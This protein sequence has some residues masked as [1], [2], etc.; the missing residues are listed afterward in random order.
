MATL[1]FLFFVYSIFR[2]LIGYFF[3]LSKYV[4]TSIF[5]LNPS[6]QRAEGS[7]HRCIVGPRTFTLIAIHEKS[8]LAEA[9]EYLHRRVVTHCLFTSVGAS[10]FDMGGFGLI[11]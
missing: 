11:G 5:L 1:P 4:L 3:L 2:P 6:G 7:P 10:S 8:R 9:E